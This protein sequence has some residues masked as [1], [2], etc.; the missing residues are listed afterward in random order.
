MSVTPSPIAGFAGQFFDNNGTILSGGKIF[1]YAAGTTTPQATY[2]NALGLTPHANPIILDSAGRVPGGE[3]WL[4]DGLVYKFVIETSTNILIGTYDNITGVNSNFVNYTVQEEVI[5][6]TAGQTVFNLST[7]NYAPGTNSLS[8]Y[9]DGVNQYVG[10]SYLETDSDTVT[11]TAGLHV[12]A[13]VKFTTAVQVTTSTSDASLVSYTANFPGAVQQTVQTKLDQSVSVKDFG[14]VGDGVTNDTAAFTAANASSGQEIYVPVGTY[15]INPATVLTKRFYGPGVISGYV[16]AGAVTFTGAGLNDI[17]LTG[18]YV[19]AR[20]LQIV[21][22]VNAVNQTGIS[23]APSPC[24]TFEYSLNG[25]VTF[26]STYDAYNPVDDQVYALPLGMNALIGY[27]LS[28]PVGLPGTGIVPVFASNTGHTVGNTWAFTLNPNPQVLDTKSGVITKNGSPIMG[29]NGT[30]ETNTFLGK[31]VFGNLNNAGNQNTVVGWRAMYANTTGYANTVMGVT[32]MPDNTSGFNNTAIGANALF[33]NTT[34]ITNTA[35]GIYAS[36]ANT[37]GAGNVSIGSDANAYN[38]TGDGNTATGTQS[39]YHNTVGVENAALGLYALR[40]GPQSFGN[41][42]SQNYCTAIGS[43]SLY[44]GGGQMNAAIGYSAGLKNKGNFNTYL[45]AETGSVTTEISGGFNIFI[46]YRSGQNAAQ[47]NTG[48]NSIAIGDGTY[49][50]GD[51][52]VAIGSGVSSAANIFTVCNG[53]HTFFRPGVDNVTALGAPSNLWSVVY[54]ATPAINTSDERK[55]QQIK[56]IDKA[57]LRAWAKVEYC[58]FKF[59]D[60]V[61]AKGDGARWHI[62]LIAQRVKD[63]FESEGLDAFEYGLLCYDEWDGGDSYGI[64]YEEALALECAYLR[65]KLG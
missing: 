17:T 32:A 20:P 33:K 35:V 2:T 14:A 57:A 34:G 62:G 60:A 54:S 16:G 29:V 55:K 10:D 6:A 30:T 41:G 11:F 38:T 45:G 13:E 15:V 27:T 58:Q 22:R 51:N 1:T 24:D 50:T 63:A 37:S 39:L 36:Q 52:A 25:G 61:E 19:Q 49:T 46:G 26:I 47:S 64:R 28:A 48:Q 40:G 3:I 7:I 65:S 8:V 42:T 53:S 21:L 44:E 43:Y 4:T 9:I 59:N 56:P 18:S 5:T 23:G 12:G 31:D